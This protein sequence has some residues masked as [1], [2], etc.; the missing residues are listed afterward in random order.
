MCGTCF[1]SR[2]AH[3]R[4]NKGKGITPCNIPAGTFCE[5]WGMLFYPKYAKAVDHHHKSTTI[6]NLFGRQE[7]EHKSGKSEVQRFLNYLLLSRLCSVSL[8]QLLL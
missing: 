8:V 4:S 2:N 3:A 1:G 7:V 5:D 6:D